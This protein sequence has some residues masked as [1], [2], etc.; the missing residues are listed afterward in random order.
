VAVGDALLSV[1]PFCTIADNAYREVGDSKAKGRAK[2]AKW[3]ERMDH[4][5]TRSHGKAHEG[6]G[7]LDEKERWHETLP[8]P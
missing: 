4:E 3:A 7:Y 1:A 5:A 2:K 6:G 8:H